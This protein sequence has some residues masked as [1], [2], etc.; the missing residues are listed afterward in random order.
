M[1]RRISRRINKLSPIKTTSP[2]FFSMNVNPNGASVGN[3]VQNMKGLAELGS[4]IKK[5]ITN[6]PKR[7]KRRGIF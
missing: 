6:P 1:I 5:T 2:S 4:A 7:K 3:F